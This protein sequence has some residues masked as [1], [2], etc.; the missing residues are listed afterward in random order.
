MN[1]VDTSSWKYFKLIGDI[2]PTYENCKC[3]NASDLDEGEDI[4]Y[5]GAK[6]ENNGAMRMVA[7]NDELVTEGNCI[8]FICDG[9]GSVGYSLYMNEDFIGSTTLSV[10]R[11]DHLNPYNAM[12]LVTILDKERPKYSFGRKYRKNLEKTNIK[13]PADKDGNPDWDYMESYIKKVGIEPLVSKNEKKPKPNIF[14]TKEQYFEL[15]KV[16]DDFLPAKGTTTD[17]LLP[18]DDIPYIGAKK[19]NSGLMEMVAREGNEQFISEGN[20]I[21]FVQ[22]GEGSAGYTTYQ[23]GD[24]IGMNGKVCCGISSKLNKYNAM[25]L[26][27]ILDK[28]RPKFSFGRSWTGDRLKKTRIK[29]PATDKGEIDWEF[30][31]KVIRQLKYSDFIS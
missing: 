7:K 4:L 15:E 23:N 16:F 24:F 22:L 21:V 6:K 10:A 25:Y 13:L 14:S 19:E 30:M 18:G 11:N 2:F 29:L 9:E 26:V 3:S 8:I 12:F 5:V 20:C 28:E 27:T 17:E 31:E 1:N